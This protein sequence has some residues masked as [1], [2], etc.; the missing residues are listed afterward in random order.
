[1]EKEKLLTGLREQVGQTGLSE[2]TISEY[3][4]AI[5]PTVTDE[6]ATE[7]FFQL[8]GKILKTME[9]QLNNEVATKVNGFKADWEKSHPTKTT[10]PDKK[11]E[12][13]SFKDTEEYKSL[14]DEIK[15]LKQARENEAKELKVQSL[16]SK[17]MGKSSELNVSNKALW[18]DVVS[19]LQVADDANEE[20]VLSAAK[21]TYEAKLK[22]YMPSAVPFGANADGTPSAAPKAQAEARRAAFKARM[23]A[24]GRL[25]EE[26]K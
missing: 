10:E 1:M 21:S 19:S 9:G 8:H 26:A 13:E 24:E 6:A 11:V 14:L 4:D 7:A 5:L 15:N 16:R 20:S 3:V 2:R 25:P 23:I 12:T 22:A 18:N 17:V